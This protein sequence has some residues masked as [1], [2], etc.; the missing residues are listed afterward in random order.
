[1]EMS[2]NLVLSDKSL[3]PHLGYED[4]LFHMVV[5]LGQVVSKPNAPMHVQVHDS[6]EVN[7]S[8]PVFKMTLCDSSL[9]EETYESFSSTGL[10]GQWSLS[11]TTGLLNL[12]KAYEFND[13][14]SCKD[15]LLDG[16]SHAIIR[17]R[18][19]QIL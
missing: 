6:S 3:G 17:E 1:M 8:W 9:I 5:R 16:Q 14:Q 15:F 2:T 4:Y 7:G 10:A 19:M 11:G 13:E 18:Y 12:I